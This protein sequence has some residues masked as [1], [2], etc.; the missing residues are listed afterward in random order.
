LNKFDYR[1]DSAPD[2]KGKVVRYFVYTLLVFIST[3]LFVS[4]VHYV[5]GVLNVDVNQPLRELPTNV[6]FLGLLGM[7]VTLVL[8]YTVVLM[9]AR[10]I[11]RNLGV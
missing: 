10:V 5:G 11:F 9:L 6:V 4:L 7:L 2:S 8:I 3:F 1:F